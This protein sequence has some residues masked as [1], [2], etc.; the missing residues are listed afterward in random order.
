MDLAAQND[1]AARIHER[2]LLDG[3]RTCI[4]CHKGIAHDLPDMRNIEPG[5]TVPR[6]LRGGA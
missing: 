1:R 6:E 4:D 5:W 3:E 2:Y